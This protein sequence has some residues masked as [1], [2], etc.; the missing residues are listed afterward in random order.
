MKLNT[1]KE[2]L[3]VAS[4]YNSVLEIGCGEGHILKRIKAQ[5]RIGIDAFRPILEKNQIP[6]IIFINYNLSHGLTKLFLENSFECIIGFDI[7]EHFKK[8]EAIKI[9]Y[10]CEQIASKCILFFIPVGNHPQTKDDRKMG[11]DFFQTHR[12]KWYP[13]DMQKLGYDVTFHPNW[14]NQKGKDRGAMFCY[15]NILET[16][17]GKK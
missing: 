7:I 3:E 5:I 4:K 12:S 14:H 10:E 1:V 15:K 11:N 13:E 6:N 9:I 16:K 17:N 8:D 2:V